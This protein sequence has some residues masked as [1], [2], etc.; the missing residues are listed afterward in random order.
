MLNEL[1]NRILSAEKA[2]EEEA[3][4][5]KLSTDSLLEEKRGQHDK[6][7]KAEIEKLYSSAEKDAAEA[8][9]KVIQ[10]AEIKA[11]KIL[12]TDRAIMQ[13]AVDLILSKILN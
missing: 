10:E 2:A 12:E 11:A 9:N 7:R 13:K 6:M 1:V 8:Y 3:E 4:A 5:I